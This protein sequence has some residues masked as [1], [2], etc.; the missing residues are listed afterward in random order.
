M[1]ALKLLLVEF[2]LPIKEKSK[3]K[4]SL[5]ENLCLCFHQDTTSNLTLIEIIT[6][7]PSNTLR[8]KSKGVERQGKQF[9]LSVCK[10]NINFLHRIF[11]F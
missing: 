8:A 7:S 9:S 10:G 3:L 1:S 2:H 11:S 5:T 4:H 6:N